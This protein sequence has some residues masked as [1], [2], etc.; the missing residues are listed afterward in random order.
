MRPSMQL[1]FNKFQSIRSLANANR[2]LCRHEIATLEKRIRDFGFW[3]PAAFP[4][5][6]ITV[7][8]HVQQF[9]LYQ[10]AKLLAPDG[11]SPGM[12]SEQAIESVHVIMN[13]LQKRYRQ[14]G[15]RKIIEAMAHRFNLYN[16]L[17]I[18]VLGRKRPRICP[19]CNLPFARG[20]GKFCVCNPNKHVKRKL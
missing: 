10:I 15:K 3:F 18:P 8:F 20:A 16:N 6:S 7:K 9:H 1:L 17:L 14:K 2:P 5:A 12:N 11:I 4:N 19:H 13:K